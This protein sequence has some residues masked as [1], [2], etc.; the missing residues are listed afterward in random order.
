MPVPTLAKE[1]PSLFERKSSPL[2][3]PA[4]VSFAG[5]LG[6]VPSAVTAEP[7]GIAIRMVHVDPASADE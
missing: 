2:L 3:V 6:R 7:L 5:W 1:I 4:R